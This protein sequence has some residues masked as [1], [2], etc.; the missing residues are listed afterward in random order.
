MSGMENLLLQAT[1]DESWSHSTTRDE[2][3]FSSMRWPKNE[4]RVTYFSVVATFKEFFVLS[5]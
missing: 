2:V 3:A 1:L 4:Q 5:S